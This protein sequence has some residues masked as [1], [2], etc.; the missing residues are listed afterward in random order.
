[1]VKYS[2]HHTSYVIYRTGFKLAQLKKNKVQEV[3]NFAHTQIPIGKKAI[4]S[5]KLLEFQI[6]RVFTAPL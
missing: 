4:T 1:M 2:E 3:T 6:D 5:D